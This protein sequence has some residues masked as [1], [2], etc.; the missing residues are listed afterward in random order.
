MLTFVDDKTLQR[1]AEAFGGE[2]AVQII[3][4]L[5]GVNETT[6]DEIA[7]QT[8]I[9]LNT[10]R[11]IL[12]KLYD[13]SLV[14]LRRSR[15]KTTGWFIFHWRLQLDQLAGFILNQ[16][17]RVLEKLETR[18][19][20]ENAHDFY[21]CSTEGCKRIPFEEAMELVFRCPT[22]NKLLMHFDNTELKSC[23]EDHIKNLRKELG[24]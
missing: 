20:Y 24:E 12:Y 16:K 2:D 10:V 1:V 13:H 18:L 8:E 21:S 3:N 19:E 22:C 15:D 17:R 11:K 9:R 4:A 14:G 23:L 7:A 5:K 6:D